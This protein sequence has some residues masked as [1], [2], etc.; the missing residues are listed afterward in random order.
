MQQ[1][2]LPPRREFRD[3]WGTTSREGYEDR[4]AFRPQRT[5]RAERGSPLL[6]SMGSFCI[7]GG[8]CWGVYLLTQHGFQPEVLQQNHGPVAIIGIGAVGSILGKYLRV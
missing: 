1:T 6:K 4:G 7:V 2:S 5:R 8:M 3:D